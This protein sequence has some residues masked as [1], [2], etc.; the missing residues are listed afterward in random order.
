MYYEILS[1]INCVG[2]D[3]LQTHIYFLS[4]LN[5]VTSIEQLNLQKIQE[6]SSFYN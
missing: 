2:L 5:S 6:L 1:C 4:I 3:K